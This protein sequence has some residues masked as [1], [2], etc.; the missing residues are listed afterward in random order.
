MYSLFSPSVMS[1]LANASYYASAGERTMKLDDLYEWMQSA[2][3]DDLQPNTTSIDP[4]HRGLQRRY[5]H[6]LIA[7]ALA[8]SFIVEAIGYPSDTVPLA[9]Y[10]LRRLDARLVASLRGDRLDVATRAHL[11]DLHARVESALHASATR[12]A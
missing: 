3:W 9:T 1:R 11:E 5:T 10:E 8:P 6:L 2:V 7:Y 12:G 4:I